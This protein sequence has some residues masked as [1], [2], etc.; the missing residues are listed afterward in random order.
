MNLEQLSTMTE[1]EL[2]AKVN[3]HL[4]RL[5]VPMVVSSA[6]A[7]DELAYQDTDADEA[8][9]RSVTWH[10]AHPPTGGANDFSMDD[11]ALAEASL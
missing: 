2:Q 8:V 1:A 10:L 3:E 11:V 5:A 7:R 4:G 6:K 9:V